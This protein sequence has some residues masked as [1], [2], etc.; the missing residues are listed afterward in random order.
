MPLQ[1]PV[2]SKSGKTFVI[3]STHGTI[4]T[5]AHS[6]LHRLLLVESSSSTVAVWILHDGLTKCL[7]ERLHVGFPESDTSPTEPDTRQPLLGQPVID[8]AWIQTEQLR[9]LLY[10]QQSLHVRIPTNVIRCL[11]HLS[12]FD[13]E[14]HPFACRV[15]LCELDLRQAGHQPPFGPWYG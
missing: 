11:Q 2:R 8:G 9:E 12:M 7:Q 1:Q 10:R 4:T 13:I 15:R 3:A 14:T 6:R 5:D